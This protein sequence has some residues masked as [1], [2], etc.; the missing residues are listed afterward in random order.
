[1]LASQS[2]SISCTVL[3]TVYCQGGG[4]C[5]GAAENTRALTTDTMLSLMTFSSLSQMRLITVCCWPPIGQLGQSSALIGQYGLRRKPTEKESQWILLSLFSKLTQDKMSWRNVHSVFFSSKSLTYW[6]RK[7]GKS[8][9]NSDTI[10]M[11]RCTL[12]CCLTLFSPQ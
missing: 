8:S 2:L 7:K 6:R 5:T 1:M 10:K 3:F 11:W 9:R 12:Y 4:H